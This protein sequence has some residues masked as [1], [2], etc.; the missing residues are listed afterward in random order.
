MRSSNSVFTP[1]TAGTSRC[2]GNSCSMS[3][4]ECLYSVGQ[5]GSKNGTKMEVVGNSQVE[6]RRG[7]F[8]I[9]LAV[10]MRMVS[11]GEWVLAQT[12]CKK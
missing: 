11:T 9:L 8:D 7:K 1:P 6:M 2:A 10:Q 3:K 4:A 12:G 5:R